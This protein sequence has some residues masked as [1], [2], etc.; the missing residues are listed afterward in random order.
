MMT[1]HTKSFLLGLL[2]L[3]MILFLSQWFQAELVFHRLN[4]EQ[5]QW[6]RIVSG[7]YTHSNY[8]HLFMN[9]VGLWIFGFIFVDSLKLKTF[10]TCLV[11]LSFIVGACL[12]L[13]NSDLLKYYGFSGILYG[14]FICGASVSMTQKDYFTGIVIL[15]GISGKVIWDHI[16]GGNIASAELIGIPVAT[17]AHIYGVIG[18]FVISTAIYY[19]HKK[20]YT[21]PLS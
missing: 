21:P 11:T 8:P 10:I 19:Q 20:R 6:W 2:V 12:Y 7:N 4:I 14:L 16:Y 18:G 3:S 5:G 13:F 1:K 9:L 15:F 17:D